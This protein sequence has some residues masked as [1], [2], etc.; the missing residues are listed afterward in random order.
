M[1][2]R[3]ETEEVL[4][5][6]MDR[7]IKEVK[8]VEMLKKAGKD[9]G[10]TTR[11]TIMSE[12]RR[13]GVPIMT[14]TKAVR[15]TPEGLEVEREDQPAFLPAD[16]IVLA[17]GS[18]KENTLLNQAEQIVPEVFVIGDAQEPRKALDAIREG[19]LLGLSI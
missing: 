1:A 17:T 16:T 14:G 10:L 15:I 7:G 2:N 13:L 3:A 11:W 9:V 12:L 6:L 5:S 18:R 4:T 8:V 19:F